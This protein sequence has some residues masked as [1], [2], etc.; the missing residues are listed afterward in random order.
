MD[1]HDEQYRAFTNHSL[2]LPPLFNAQVTG[3]PSKKKSGEGRILREKRQYIQIS[4][5]GSLGGKRTVSRIQSFCPQ[6]T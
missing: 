4:V 1:D 6:N 2:R 3:L 5:F